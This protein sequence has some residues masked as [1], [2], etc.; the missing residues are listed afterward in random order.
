MGGRLALTRAFT[1]VSLAMNVAVLAVICSLLGRKS[2]RMAVVYGPETPARG[3]LLSVYLSI[4]LVSLTLLVLIFVPATTSEGLWMSAALFVVQIV[5][6][7]ISW[8]TTG[9]PEGMKFNPVAASNLGIALFHTITF[10][11]IV[12]L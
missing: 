2:Q 10:V 4:L 1:T 6:K 5:Y 7:C 12:T 3:I 11:I 9:V 8:F